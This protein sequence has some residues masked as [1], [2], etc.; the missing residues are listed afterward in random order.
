MARWLGDRRVCDGL[1]ARERG[2]VGGIVNYNELPISMS[3]T[4][5]R[6]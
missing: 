1:G 2:L 3:T 6:A 5:C 4:A